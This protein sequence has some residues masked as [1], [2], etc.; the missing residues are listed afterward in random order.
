MK[1]TYEFFQ[2]PTLMQFQAYFYNLINKIE[3]HNPTQA[4]FLKDIQ[5]SGLRFQELYDLSFIISNTFTTLTF[6]TEKG[7]NNRTFN[8]N[9]FSTYYLQLINYGLPLYFTTSLSNFYTVFNRY[10]FPYKLFHGDKV[11]SAHGLRHLYAKTLFYQ[12]LS[13]EEIRVNMGEVNILNSNNYIDSDIFIKQV[14]Y[15]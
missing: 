1:P 11:L 4:T 8:K 7:S 2:Q 15:G 13:R 12:G 10:E 6:R 5:V 14:T 9:I 3:L